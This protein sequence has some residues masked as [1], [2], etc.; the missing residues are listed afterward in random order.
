[1]TR[2]QINALVQPVTGAFKEV[3]YWLQKSG[4]NPE[5]V[6]IEREWIT[7]VATIEQA[8]AMLNTKF[9][10]YQNQ[11]RKNVIKIRTLKYS[12]PTELFQYVDLI[13]PTTRF[14]QLKAHSNAILEMEHSTTLTSTVTVDCNLTITPSCLQTMYNINGFTPDPVKGGIFGVSGFLEEYAQYG[15]LQQFLPTYAPWAVSGN[16]T[17]TSVNGTFT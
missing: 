10:I 14:G 3:S 4:V 17:W 9:N 6:K 5:E 1:L 12:L 16:F 15:D 13:Q 2:K 11:N 7:F 8:E